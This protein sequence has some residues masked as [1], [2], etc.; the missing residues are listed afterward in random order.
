RQ[1]HYYMGLYSYCYSASLTIATAA[2]RLIE[3]EGAPAVERWKEMLKAGSTLGP[4]ELAKLAGVDITTDQPLKETI[5]YIGEI[6]DQI[7]Q[8][9][10]E[11]D[12]IHID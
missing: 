6:V 12:G 10:E 5:A 2:C 4:I 3:K 1:P 7:C 11:I 9:T 8:L